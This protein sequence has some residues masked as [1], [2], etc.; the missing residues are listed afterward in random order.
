MKRMLAL[1]FSLLAAN[2]A[3]AAETTRYTALVNGGKTKAGHMWQTTNDNV[4]KVDFLIKDNGRG[5]ELKE[6]FTVAKDGGFVAYH[7]EGQST[8]GALINETFERK[9]DQVSWK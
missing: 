8:F 7:V 6:E 5:P 3:I 9:G 2:A 1:G 4:T